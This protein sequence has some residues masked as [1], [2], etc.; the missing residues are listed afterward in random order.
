MTHHKLK[1]EGY[2]LQH[3]KLMR[4]WSEEH[5]EIHILFL[6]RSERLFLKLENQKYLVTNSKTQNSYKGL[7]LQGHRKE[8][9][10]TIGMPSSLRSLSLMCLSAVIS[11]CIAQQNTLSPF[12]GWDIEMY[13]ENSN[14][15]LHCSP[16]QPAR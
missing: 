6:Q 7:L 5:P 8:D 13:K 16:P 15:A 2:H 12:P 14:E 4:L 10:L 3:N 11:T 1:N 9:Q